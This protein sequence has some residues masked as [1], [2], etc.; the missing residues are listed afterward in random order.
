MIVSENYQQYLRKRAGL[1]PSSPVDSS[2]TQRPM[3]CDGV[4]ALGCFQ[5]RLYYD[6]FLIPGSCKCWRPDY[7]NK[8]VRRKSDL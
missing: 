5:V 2:T 1:Q 6:W 7:F 8:Y 4:D 3:Q